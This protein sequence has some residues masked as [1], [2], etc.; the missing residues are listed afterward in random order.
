MKVRRTMV[1]LM[2]TALSG[3]LVSVNAAPAQTA[4][5]SPSATPPS[6][7][8]GTALQEIIVTAQKRSENLQTVPIAATAVSGVDIERRQAV[9]IEGLNGTVPNVQISN[10]ANTPN[11]ASIS[12]RGIGVIDPDPYAGNTVSV[13]YDGV[14]Q[15]FSMG[16][17]V[18]LYD[19]DRVEV[20][21]GPQGTLFG[22][23]TTGGAINIVTDQPTGKFGFKGQLTYGNWNRFDAKGALDVPIVDN[24]LSGKLVYSHTQRDG[25]VTNI[26]DG[27]PIGGRDVDLTRGYLKFTPSSS[28]TATL[29]AEWVRAR[30]GTPQVVN[31]AYP[32]DLLFVPPGTLGMYQGPCQPGAPCKA[33]D[34]YLSADN[35][36][37]DRSNMDTHRETLNIEARDTPLGTIT[38]IT[39]YKFFRI[40]EYTDQDATPLDLITTRRYTRGWQF[41]QELR[42]AFDINDRINGIVGAFYLKDH[43][44]SHIGTKLTFAGP[45]LIQLNDQDQDNYSISG[46]T[47][48]YA[49][50]TD[51]LKLQGGVRFTHENTSMLASSITSINP[52]GVTDYFATGNTPILLVT[53]PRGSK[54]WDKVGWKLGAEYQLS[55]RSMIYASWA[56]GFK[57]GGFAGRLGIAQDLGPFNPETVDT[58]EIGLKTELFD[59]RLRIN[60][61]AFWTNYRNMQIA[62]IYFVTIDGNPVQGNT[63]VNAAKSRIK[64][65]EFEATAIPLPHLNI[66]GFVSYLDSKYRDFP[67][68]DPTTV[69][70]ANPLGVVQNLR[71]S[72]LQNAPKWQASASASYDLEIGD[73]RITPSISYQYTSSKYFTSAL[74]TIRSKIQPTHIVD[75]NIEWTLPGNRF[76]FSLWGT[77]LLDK[78]YIAAVADTPGL[79]GFVSYAPPREYGVTAKV[80]F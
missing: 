38:S 15:Y 53:P 48:F 29:T 66:R 69:S 40:L 35:S 23:N 4:N 37:P 43:Y 22:A 79:N 10:F 39:G 3:G 68:V 36:E 74:D 80:N 45:G 11:T 8:S 71:G 5:G 70:P 31:G 46:F 30:N 62:K 28:V 72:R 33:P 2:S 20:L 17:L 75:A 6:E 32:T 47:Q 57:S 1:W 12:I 41:S 16:A 7:S 49:R 63:I 77:N 50:V 34:K 51:R 59:R 18:D 76:A 9:T 58:Y 42:S 44:V 26:V 78:R 52:S 67:F 61:A 56:R 24:I 64:G 65:L 55:T 27:K 13:I 19:I 25:W 54:S 21:R 73:H 14:P 60:A